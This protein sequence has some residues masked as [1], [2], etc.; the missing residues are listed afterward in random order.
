MANSWISS[1]A[2][3]KRDWGSAEQHLNVTIDRLLDDPRTKVLIACE[4]NQSDRIVGWC[5]YAKIPGARVLEFILVRQQRRGQGIARDLLTR[6]G[7]LGPGAPLTALFPT[8]RLK[9]VQLS[10]QDFL[11]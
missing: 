1:L 11:Q 8:T 4:V 2:G 6:A 7:L 3:P 9:A 10:P 5:A